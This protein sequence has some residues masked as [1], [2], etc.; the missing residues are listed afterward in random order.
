MCE[1]V[2]NVEG[3]QSCLCPGTKAL[4]RGELYFVPYV[5]PDISHGMHG[6][7][8]LIWYMFPDIDVQIDVP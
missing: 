3:P 6:Y 5:F 2:I 7:S 8:K 1:F 4:V